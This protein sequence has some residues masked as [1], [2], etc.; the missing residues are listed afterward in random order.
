MKAGDIVYLVVHSDGGT[1]RSLPE[2]AALACYEAAPANQRDRMAVVKLQVVDAHV[3]HA[4]ADTLRPPP[5]PFG[6]VAGRA[7]MEKIESWPLCQVCGKSAREGNH[8]TD[9]G[10]GHDYVPRRTEQVTVDETEL[11]RAGERGR[12]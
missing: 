8:C 3:E 9:L 7:E 5:D 6:V 1:S 2:A 11:A 10:V 12:E 4:G